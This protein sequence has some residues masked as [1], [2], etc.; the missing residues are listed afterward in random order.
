MYTYINIH[1]KIY[2]HIYIYDI[3]TVI[4]FL[5]IQSII[6]YDIYNRLP[7]PPAGSGL[8]EDAGP[9]CLRRAAKSK[10]A[11]YRKPLGLVYIGI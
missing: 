4:L 1:I 10:S 7:S 8:S 6:V 11:D 2:I 5:C 3:H 9:E